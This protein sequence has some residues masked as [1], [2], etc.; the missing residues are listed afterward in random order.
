MTEIPDSMERGGK[1]MEDAQF[2]AELLEIVKQN[3]S[4]AYEAVIREKASYPYL[5][6]LSEIRQNLIDW[7]PITK[8]MRV[9]ECNAECGALTGKL[10]AMAGEVVSV[11]EDEVH[12]QVIR[13]RCKDVG[14]R[15]KVIP[16]HSKEMPDGWDIPE[17]LDLQDVRRFDA[18]LIAGD[19]Y[20]FRAKLTEL[21]GLL[22][23]DGR[24]YVADAN[25]LGLK[26]F[27]GCQ[28]EYRGGYF[29]GIEGY[30]R[31]DSAALGREGAKTGDRSNGGRCYSRIEYTQMLE[32]A[33][34]EKLTF[35]YPYP[36]HKFP[37]AIYSDA[38]LP[39]KGELAENRRNFDRDRVE[40]FDE[41]KVYDSLLAEGLFGSFANSFLI[42]ARK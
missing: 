18:I 7:L 9:L 39:H 25:R 26:Y 30:D 19:V 1:R 24:L 14:G 34:F 11:T 5:Y 21:G 22:K 41:Q 23:E 37:A 29:T 15:L 28:E 36:D 32:N 16:A 33:G 27:A 17:T 2:L 4:D 12:A 13:E 42:E 20:R 10:L 3:K 35:Y 6:H 31:E 38:W 40:S 8:K